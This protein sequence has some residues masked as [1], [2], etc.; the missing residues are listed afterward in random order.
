VSD[1]AA[2]HDLRTLRG[3]GP[4]DDLA[5]LPGDDVLRFAR[6]A[7]A[8]VCIH[9]V[10]ENIDFTDAAGW[11]AAIG[12][13]LRELG[14]DPAGADARAAMLRT[15]LDDV[16][17]T[18]LPF[19]GVRPLVLATVSRQRRLTELEFHLPSNRLSS[20][21]LNHLLEH[22]GYPAPRLAFTALA[23]F[24]KGF[25][26]LVF[27]HDGRFFVLDWKS[28]HLGV[29]PADYGHDAVAAE[30]ARQGYHLQSLLYCVALD[31]HLRR[32]LPGYQYE[33]HFGG[34]VYLFVRGVRPAWRTSDGRPAGAWLHRPGPEV[35]RALSAL[36]DGDSSD[37][38]ASRKPRGPARGGHG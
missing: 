28:N 7:Q 31:R 16:L 22:H 30:M 9:T 2:D 3:P 19:E 11:D 20:D 14:P 27:E 8:G 38:A 37:A 13:A 17:A 12:A 4:V 36:L 25:I 26:D 5:L 34:V 24:L 18:P 35:I 15:M 21:D 32:R 1:E 23:G 6:G 10:F 29:Q 33:Q